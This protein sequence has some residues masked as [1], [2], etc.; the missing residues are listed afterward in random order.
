M[1]LV[2]YLRQGSQ[3]F[4]TYWTTARGV[5]YMDNSYRLLDLT[6]YGRQENWEDS[7]AGWPQECTY[8]R[9]RTGSPDWEPTWPGGRPIAQWPRLEAGR[10]DDL[11]P[12]PPRGR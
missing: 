5:E 10:S 4:E 9:T 8:T 6:V 11:G 2:C 12:A 7:P 1:H 3:V